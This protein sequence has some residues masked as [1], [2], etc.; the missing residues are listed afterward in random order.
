MKNKKVK[1]KLGLVAATALLLLAGLWLS[2]VSVLAQ[3]PGNGLLGASC[4]QA[5]DKQCDASKNLVC[6][7]GTYTCQ[8]NKSSGGNTSGGGN[9]LLGASCS[10]TDDKPC[11][12]S[13]NLVC[14]PD[15]YTCQAQ[16]VNG[17]G[18]GGPNPGGTGSAIQCPTGTENLNGFCVPKSGYN[19]KSIAGTSTLADL[20]LTVINYL[21]ILSGMI[22]VIAL[23]VGGF[24]Y[25]TAAGN[26]EQVEKGRKA[27]VNA[28]IGL[29]VVI[30]AY[31]IVNI[32]IQTF[33]TTDILKKNS[34][35]TTTTN[36][37]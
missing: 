8:P 10:Q 2:P 21:L 11:D 25:I 34:T 7:P 29:I 36:T 16:K 30:L 23:I 31:A 32:V 19:T 20:I 3:A 22:A 18:N 33:T 15:T 5:D 27:I 26:E 12:A 14:D 24:W 1:F 9:G 28:I 4:S 6:D 13:K 37:P 35:T 17:G